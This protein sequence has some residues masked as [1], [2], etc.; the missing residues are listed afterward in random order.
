MPEVNIKHNIDHARKWMTDVQRKQIPYALSVAMGATVTGARRTAIRTA[1]KHLDNP[2]PRVLETAIRKYAPRKNQVYTRAAKVFIAKWMAPKYRDLVYGDTVRQLSGNTII[3][4]VN[5]DINSFG[6]VVGLRGRRNILRRIREL[7]EI[8]FEFV[9]VP[10]GAESEYGGL[11]AGLYERIGVGEFS[12]NL[13]MLF[14]YEEQRTYKPQWPLD[15]IV[16]AEF[17]RLFPKTFGIQLSS[18]IKRNHR[19]MR[20]K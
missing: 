3:T 10:L 11:H 8:G 19:H 5:A 7:E 9:E 12:E 13:N 4:P 16:Y 17:E 20:P 2:V 6:N 15:Q 14:S 1:P 18:Q